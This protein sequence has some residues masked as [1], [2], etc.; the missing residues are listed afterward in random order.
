VAVGGIRHVPGVHHVRAPQEPARRKSKERVYRE[1]RSNGRGWN[2]L[3][4]S[5]G[6]WGTHSAARVRQNATKSTKTNTQQST[7]R[8]AAS[9]LHLEY[10]CRDFLQYAL[11]HRS[12]KHCTSFQSLAY[13][14]IFSKSTLQ[15]TTEA[16]TTT[17]VIQHTDSPVP[18]H[19]RIEGHRVESL[20]GP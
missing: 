9:S 11:K 7:Q 16:T 5:L 1:K 15:V 8:C 19:L 3:C 18:D 20:L 2:C 4:L 6:P 17:L 14:R 13:R 12:Q 10:Y